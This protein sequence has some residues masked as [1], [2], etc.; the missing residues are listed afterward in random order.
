MTRTL[1]RSRLLS[2]TCLWLAGLLL[3]GPA[4]LRA[5]EAEAPPARSVAPAVPAEPLA[6]KAELKAAEQRAEAR[7][8]ALSTGLDLQAQR[9]EDQA[10][11]LSKSAQL[12]IEAAEDLKTLQGSQARSAAALESAQQKLSDLGTRLQGLE[13]GAAKTSSDSVVRDSRLDELAKAQ[14]ALRLQAQEGQDS[15]QTLLKDLSAS[16][17][18]LKERGQK[19]NSLTDLL[20][21]MKQDLDGNHEELVEVKQA[22]KRLE[23][24]PG[25]PEAG[26]WL[27]RALRWPYLPAV[28]VGLSAVAVGLAVAR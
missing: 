3:L 9:L 24:A 17:T 25:A 21:V 26:S 1:R 5:A 4:P 11:R 10:R 2:P 13:Q 14:A 16:R 7:L 15:L 28:A 6:T 18:E 12:L 19:L 8:Q 22:L 20:G 27:D 23:P